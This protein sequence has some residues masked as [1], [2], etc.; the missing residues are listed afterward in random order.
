MNGVTQRKEK[1]FFLILVIGMIAA[2]LWASI[3]SAGNQTMEPVPPEY[4]SRLFNPERIHEIDIRMADWSGLMAEAISESY[5]PCTVV[6]D[7]ETFR[8]VGIRPKGNTSL[9]SVLML[10]SPRYSLKI[11]FDHFIRGQTCHGLDVL[12]LNN[13]IQ[14]ATMMKEALSYSLMHDMQV[15]AP[16]CSYIRVSVNGETLGL[17]LAV[18]GIGRSFLSRVGWPDGRIYKPDIM[19]NN[20]GNGMAPMKPPGVSPDMPPGPAGPPPV[21]MDANAVVFGR[22][23][24]TLGIGEDLKLKDQGNRISDYPNI[25]GQARNQTGRMEQLR[26]VQAIQKLNGDHRPGDAVDEEEIMRYLVIQSFLSNEDSYTGLMAHNYYL[27]EE[28]GKLHM[29]PW[30][31]NLAF[32]GVSEDSE[33]DSF[34]Q[35]SID[36]PVTGHPVSDR[37]LIAWIFEDPVKTEFYHRLMEAFLREQIENGAIFQRIGEIR[38]LIEEEQAADPTAFYDSSRF[39]KAVSTLRLFCDARG[40]NMIAQLHGEKPDEIPF[41]SLTDMGGVQELAQQLAPVAPYYQQM[42]NPFTL[43]PGE[44]LPLMIPFVLLLLGGILLVWMRKS[45]NG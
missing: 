10:G 15:P 4:E 36:E 19:Q 8:N 11:E 9:T 24:D 28:N 20:A 3:C 2:A 22:I 44:S 1:N 16:L 6:L 5:R 38:S 31:C 23:T 29:I 33:A 14:D 32:G 34:I 39:R 25:A 26:L 41:I 21:N 17:Y 30:D 43:L 13:Q 40:R 18:E 7:G 12:N 42:L 35:A 45:H 27:C 37:P